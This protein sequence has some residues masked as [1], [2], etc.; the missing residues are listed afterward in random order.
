MIDFSVST[1]SLLDALTAISAI[2][3]NKPQRDILKCIKIQAILGTDEKADSLM[4]SATDLESYI[5]YTIS[6]NVMIHHDGSFVVSALTILDY[7]K[8][9]EDDTVKI[10]TTEED[11]LKIKESGAEFEVV[12]QEVAEYPEFPEV[13]IAKTGWITLPRDLMQN[14]LDK[15]VFAVAAHGH[16]KWG[17]L[18]SVCFNLTKDSINLIGTDTY[19]ASIF[20]F[21]IPTQNIIEGQ[22]LIAAKSMLFLSKVFTADFQ[23]LP[24]APNN[25]IF[26]NNE[27]TLYLRL[28]GGNFPPVK[29][30]VP[31]HP[32]SIQLTVAEFTKQIK[33][34]ALAADKHNTVKIE[35]QEGKLRLSANTRELRKNVKVE[36]DLT[37]KGIGIKFAV[38]CDFILGLL[39]ASEDDEVLTLH[40]NKNNEPI[41]FTQNSFVHFLVPQEAK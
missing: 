19:R 28:V 6:E 13:P 25:V 9:I 30:I 27:C 34:A 16:P 20:E 41:V 17:S 37:Y 33:K 4:L 31:K 3:P 12:T 32:Q 10:S 40:F 22:Y 23:M 29:K 21:P 1:Q 5:E 18:S 8:N 2:V 35:I 38:N 11:S 39:K 7:L 14:A 26:R 24:N 36:R 15:V